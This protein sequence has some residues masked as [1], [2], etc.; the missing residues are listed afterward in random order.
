AQ[1]RTGKRSPPRGARSPWASRIRPA[2]T[3]HNVVGNFRSPIPP[4]F[5]FLPERSL[6]G[7]IEQRRIAHLVAGAV[8]QGSASTR[9]KSGEIECRAQRRQKIVVLKG[10]GADERHAAG[11]GADLQHRNAG[12]GIDVHR[13]LPR[14]RPFARVTETANRS[15]HLSPGP[16]VL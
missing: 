11:A 6:H 15:T 7:G 4:R 5:D 9:G 12:A 10:A 2:T 1:P 3:G 14:T 13:P 8:F 16:L